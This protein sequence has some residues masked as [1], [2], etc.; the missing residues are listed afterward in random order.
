MSPVVF[1]ILNLIQNQEMQ[2]LV[3]LL[4][5]EENDLFIVAYIH[6]CTCEPWGMEQEKCKGLRRPSFNKKTEIGC[7][8]N[9]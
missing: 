2:P 7:N 6:Y 8:K 5:K 3:L 4:L 1:E 9:I